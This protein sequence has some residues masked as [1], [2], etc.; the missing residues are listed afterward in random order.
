MLSIELK[1]RLAALVEKYR[2]QELDFLEMLGRIEHK[3]RLHKPRIRV[4]AISHRWVL[5]ATSQPAIERER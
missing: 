4:R 2:Q 1:R 5:P 3:P